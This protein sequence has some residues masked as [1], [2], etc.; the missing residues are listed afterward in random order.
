MNNEIHLA[1]RA[2]RLEGDALSTLKDQLRFLTQSGRN[3]TMD[4]SAVET[5]NGNVTKVILEANTRLQQHGGS[6]HLVGVRKQVA[7]Y[8]ELLRV[9]RQLEMNPDTAVPMALPAAA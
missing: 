8:F 4:L 9:H 5:V 1:V 2:S 7:A 6:M 3:L